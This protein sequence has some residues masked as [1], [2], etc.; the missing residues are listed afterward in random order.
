MTITIP[1][2]VY[3]QLLEMAKRSGR[4]P[5]EELVRAVKELHQREFWEAVNASY[6]ALRAD[7]AAWAEVE[8]ERREWDGTLMDGLDPTE[9][10]SD[11]GA[12]LPPE[13]GRPS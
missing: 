4:S 9:R 3:R 8:A 2:A 12:P 6:A 7:P 5:E 13:E 1:D 11:D 10:W